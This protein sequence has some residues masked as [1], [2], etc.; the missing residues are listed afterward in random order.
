MCVCVCQPRRLA[1]CRGE[2][3]LGI[4]S[5]FCFSEQQIKIGPNHS[6]VFTDDA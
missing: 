5:H 4:P 6:G 2:T 1:A 3:W